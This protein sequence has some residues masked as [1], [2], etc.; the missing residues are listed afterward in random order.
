MDL[1]DLDVCPAV[2][3]L[4]E[5]VDVF[6]LAQGIFVD[7]GAVVYGLSLDEDGTE[8]V[9]RGQGVDDRIELLF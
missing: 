3:D 8:G 7:T 5:F 4:F 6:V 2:A 9:D 1:A